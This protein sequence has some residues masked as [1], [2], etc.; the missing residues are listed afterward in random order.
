[1]PTLTNRWAVLAL[2]FF[3]RAS[4]A[5]QFQS[6]PPITQHLIAEWG[7]GYTAVGLLISLYMFAGIAL[8]LP[9][10][11]LGQRFGD[12]AVVLLGLAMMTAGTA[13]FAAAPGY[14]VAFAGRVAG[15]VGVVLLNVQLTKITNDW[16]AGHRIA[17]A[18]GILMTAWPAGIAL[19]LSTLGF[20]A[21]AAGWRVAIGA[22]GVYS[23]LMLVLV[24]LLYR[25]LPHVRAGATPGVARPPL[26]AIP[27]VELGLIVVAGVVWMLPN[28][29]FIV[30]LSFTP[31]LLAARGVPA[32]LAA[33]IAGTA[34]WVSI[35]SVPAGGALTDRTGRINAFIVGGA[36]ACAA[37]MAAVPLGGS[38]WLWAVLFGVATGVWPGAVMSLPGQ[39][40]SA[41]ARSTGFGTFYTVY[42]VG[43]TALVPAAGWLQD[44]TGTAAASLWFASALMA[45]VVVVLAALRLL[46]RRWA[47]A[48]APEPAVEPAV[49]PVD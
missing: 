45:G 24:A 20:V 39:V 47:G 48:A 38:P 30:F 15:G 44:R 32:A 42:Y 28:A 7:I 25:D 33:V 18:M 12:K 40:L 35:A 4:M 23:A 46:Q 29:A 13:A 16:F 9:G 49:E 36:L 26:W 27:R 5:M 43:M 17:T 34:T 22:T 21:E 14:G 6:I 1:M 3:A 8:A 41:G 31:V 10:G 37:V 2:L 11:L 19:G